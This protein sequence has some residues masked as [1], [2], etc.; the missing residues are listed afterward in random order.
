MIAWYLLRSEVQ[1]RLVVLIIDAVV[2]LTEFDWETVKLMKSNRVPFIV[3]ANKIDKLPM[4]S[5]QKTI[6][7][8]R[9]ELQG[10]TVIPYSAKIH[11]GRRELLE[12]LGTF[13]DRKMS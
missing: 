3:L 6:D 5:K 9:K 8:L 10:E 4:S 7:H 1:H 13:P 11:T 2:G 12:T